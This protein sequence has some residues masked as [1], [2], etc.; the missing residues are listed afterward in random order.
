MSELELLTPEWPAPAQIQA[1]STTR[2][3]GLSPAPYASL[4]VGLG[5][6]DSHTNVL[7]NRATLAQ[8]AKLPAAPRWLSQVHGRDCVDAANAADGA[9]ADAS[10]AFARG[11]VCAIM[12]ADCLPILLCDFSGTRIGAAHAGWRGLAQGV[13]EATVRRLDTQPDQL[14]AWL[15]PCISAAAYEVGSEVFDT[16]VSH[17]GADAAYFSATRPGHWHADLHGL[18]RARLA[19]LSVTAVFA[20]PLCTAGDSQ[21][22]FSYRRDGVTGRMVSLIWIA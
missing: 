5:S 3:G 21:R 19:R 14:M 1:V 4:N 10:V 20:S 9:Q 11:Q 7:A 17:H 6:G 22:F 8:A 15:G 12:T 2:A 16:F 13:I 18:A